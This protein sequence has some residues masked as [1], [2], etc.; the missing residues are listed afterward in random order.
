[1][2]VLVNNL[3]IEPQQMTNPLLTTVTQG[4]PRMMKVGSPSSAE[5][6][7]ISCAD[8]VSKTV[9]KLPQSFESIRKGGRGESFRKKVPPWR[10]TF[11]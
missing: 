2:P 3:V 4:L 9:S 5:A 6:F 1:M 10:L 8:N 7:L 11:M